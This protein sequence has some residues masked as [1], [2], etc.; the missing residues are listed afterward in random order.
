MACGT[1]EG[2]RRG[3]C[4]LQ[5]EGK[6]FR[7]PLGI[8]EVTSEGLQSGASRLWTP[9]ALMPPFRY[10]G[11]KVSGLLCYALATILEQTRCGILDLFLY[12]REFG[13]LKRQGRPLPAESR[14]FRETRRSARL[15]NSS[16]TEPLA[17][18]SLGLRPPG[19]ENS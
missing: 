11:L 4:F 8:P 2:D 18:E 19:L 1:N 7:L 6:G 12:Q 9:G 17:S 14:H 3:S 16:S 10:Q 5:R 13:L 15:F